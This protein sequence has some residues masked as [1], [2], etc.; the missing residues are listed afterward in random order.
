MGRWPKR[1]TYVVLI[2]TLAF[3]VMPAASF[4]EDDTVGDDDTDDAEA[5]PRFA[6]ERLFSAPGQHQDDWEPSVAADDQGHVYI[7]TTR[8]DGPNACR[9]CPDP[10]IV[11]ERSSD[12]GR[13]WSSPRFLCPCP[14]V[15][16][17]ADP[18]LVTDER[19]RVF[20][21]WMNDFAVQFSR[22]D[23]FGRTWTDPRSVDGRL[24]WSDKPWI[25]VSEDGK[26]VYITFNGPGRSAGTPY[27][28]NSHDAGATWSR[29]V[30]GVRTNGLYWFAGGLT[31]TPEGTA[32]SSQDAYE[33][34]YKGD[35]LLYVLRSED[36]G[37]SWS[38]VPIAES[39]QGRRCP[40]FAGCG[41][42]F[43]GP[44]IAIA[45]D[46]G[47]RVYVVWNE[48]TRSGGPARIYL[49]WSDDEGETWSPA[50]KISSAKEGRVDN[51]FPMIAADDRG[52]VRVAWMDNR[53]G[54]WNTW[55]RRSADG[56]RTWSGSVRLSD[57]P[58]GAP[59]K[60]A[61]GFRFPYGDYGQLAVD[62]RGR[63]HAAWGEGPSY[64][65]PGGAWYTRG[66][67]P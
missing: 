54:R 17:Q 59:Y 21:T 14:G 18:V 67:L 52:D 44:Q 16:E 36:G 45:T 12:G 49:R 55:Y 48:T 47:G 58:D 6:P 38:R 27:T 30:G 40:R 35:V 22:S 2:C 60:S 3:G 51:E 15:E 11:F 37:R 5:H 26:D 25:G 1:L 53:T 57:R 32:I 42:G 13:S 8:F 62:G 29:P 28:V 19:G 64:N 10:A 33:Q 63:T 9:D 50:R 61:R 4:G 7:A 34:N 56:G 43:L 65:G 31:V 24:R 66:P 23:D 20:A 41:L 39:S 46:D